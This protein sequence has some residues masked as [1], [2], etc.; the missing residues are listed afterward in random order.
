[1]GQ[2]GASPKPA[3][4]DGKGYEVEGDPT[5]R[6]ILELAVVLQGAPQAT[7]QL[8]TRHARLQE[9]PFDSATKYMAT[10]HALTP[11][12]AASLASAGKEVAVATSAAGTRGDKSCY[13]HFSAERA[14]LTHS[15][16]FIYLHIYY[17]ATP[18]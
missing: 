17:Q 12:L 4:A 6:C 18:G 8:L 3:S 5:E 14:V 11:E 10:L 13:Q 2:A 15:H 16:F 7:K 9:I 1:L